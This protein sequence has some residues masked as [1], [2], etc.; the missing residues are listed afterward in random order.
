MAQSERYDSYYSLWTTPERR[1]SG[2]PIFL[3]LHRDIANK[4]ERMAGASPHTIDSVSLSLYS[5]LVLWWVS[6]FT[7]FFAIGDR[8]GFFRR[9]TLCLLISHPIISG[10]AALPLSDVICA[11]WISFAL[12]FSIRGCRL[13]ES[14]DAPSKRSSFFAAGLFSAFAALTRPSVILPSLL[15][16]ALNVAFGVMRR[17]VGR[18]VLLL[19][20]LVGFFLPL[21]GPLVSYWNAFHRVTLSDPVLVDRTIQYA[22]AVGLQGGQI[23]T[24]WNPS[25]RVHIFSDPISKESLY[26][27]C[28]IGERPF[29]EWISCGARH[30]FSMSLHLLKQTVALFDSFAMNAYA[31]ELSDA[32]SR[33]FNRV[34]GGAIFV[35]GFTG[36]VALV[37]NQNKRRSHEFRILFVF[38]L[39]SIFLAV[40]VHVETRYTFSFLSAFAFLGGESIDRVSVGLSSERRRILVLTGVS[41]ML[42]FFFQVFLW[43]V[44]MNFVP[45][46]A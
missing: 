45:S 27:Q 33:W 2:Y 3:K 43:E 30:P 16:L 6:V 10:D 34:W 22:M 12:A 42:V 31:V 4:I 46:N 39:V 19:A 14:I 36:C 35:L 41:L 26:D 15:L 23:S 8:G 29:V 24:V 32:F 13:S 18:W 17:Q 25:P 44:A 28:Y 11:A 38:S 9:L 7:L 20:L 40:L 5:V 21:S 1:P 37:V